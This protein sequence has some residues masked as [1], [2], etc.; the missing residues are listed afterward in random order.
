ME[1]WIS[2]TLVTLGVVAFRWIVTRMPILRED[3]AFPQ[4]H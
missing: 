1:V 4:G 3:A 2:M